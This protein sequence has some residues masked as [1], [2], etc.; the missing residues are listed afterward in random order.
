MLKRSFQQPNEEDLK[1]AHPNS[2]PGL[3]PQPLWL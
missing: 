1:G 2:V 3:W